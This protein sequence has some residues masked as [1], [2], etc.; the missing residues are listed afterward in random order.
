[1]LYEL[2]KREQALEAYDKATKLNP[3]SFKAQY[4]KGLLLAKSSQYKLSLESLDKALALNP[5]DLN[6]YI[7]KGVV[8][9]Q[10]GQYDLALEVLNKASKLNPKDSTI[11]KFKESLFVEVKI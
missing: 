10:L 7:V 2:G 5:N 9:E 8:L 4:S 3:R 11:Q 1:M 6:T